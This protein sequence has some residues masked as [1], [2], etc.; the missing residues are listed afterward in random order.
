[1]A[2]LIS[3]ALQ[4]TGVD[5]IAIA[6]QHR[7]ALLVCSQCDAETG[8]HIRAVQVVGDAPKALRLA[9]CEEGL[10]AHIQA[11]QLAVLDGCAGGKDFELENAFLW[12]VVQHQLVALDLEGSS[13]AID[14]HACQIELFTVQAQRLRWHIRVAPQRHLVEH[15]GLGR[16]QVKSQIDG[17]NPEGRGAVIGAANHAGRAVGV[18]KLQHA[19]SPKI[20][21]SSVHGSHAHWQ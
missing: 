4:C 3:G 12:Q 2:T 14:Q 1:M 10:V 7:V 18:T 6:Q 8:H 17:V 16:I 19:G 9:L 21:C 13:L 15:A 5:Q 11:H 20:S